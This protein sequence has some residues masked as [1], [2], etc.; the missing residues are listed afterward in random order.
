MWLDGINETVVYDVRTLEFYDM[1]HESRQES[2]KNVIGNWA[3]S[4]HCVCDIG[5]AQ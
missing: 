3:R 2:V 1:T 5:E 4:P